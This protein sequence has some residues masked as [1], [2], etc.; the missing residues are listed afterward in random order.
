[1]RMPMT[2]PARA[3]SALLQESLRMLPTLYSFGRTGQGFC[4]R[5]LA[6]WLVSALWQSAVCFWAPVYAHAHIP[7]SRRGQS[8]GLWAVG[9]LSYTMIVTMVSSLHPLCPAV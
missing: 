8:F 5:T 2:M 4:P 1:M 6:A 9:T 3:R 7:S